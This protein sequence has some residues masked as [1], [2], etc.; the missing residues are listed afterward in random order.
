MTL[1]GRQVGRVAKARLD[2]DAETGSITTPVEIG[3][4]ALA[5]D[6]QAGTVNTR[7]ELGEKM[8]QAVAKLVQNGL[9][10]KVV[11]SGFLSMGKSVELAMASRRQAS[12]P[13]PETPAPRHPLG[14]GSLETSASERPR[15]E[16]E[17]VA[18]IDRLREGRESRPFPP[19]PP[20][21][22]ETAGRA[23]SGAVLTTGGRGGYR[24]QVLWAAEKAFII[25]PPAFMTP[26][27]TASP[28]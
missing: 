6:P 17:R 4:D 13:R 21:A 28:F 23:G 1:E 22:D 19:H 25:L 3:I 24:P 12:Q 26:C 2:I 7:D 15:T 27:C 9:R 18:A 8:N 11:S 20:R 10:A 16:P 14:T 5:L